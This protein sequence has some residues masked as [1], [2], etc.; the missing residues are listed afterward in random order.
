MQETQ[1]AQIDEIVQI[2]QIPNSIDTTI[3]RRVRY[4]QH[5]DMSK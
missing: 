2:D 3:I 4:H 1:I 5:V